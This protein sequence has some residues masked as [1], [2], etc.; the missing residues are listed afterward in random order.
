LLGDYFVGY[1]ATVFNERALALDTV[2]VYAQAIGPAFAN[3]GL[4]FVP[5]ILPSLAFKMSEGP[6]RVGGFSPPFFCSNEDGNSDK[7]LGVSDVRAS[8][9]GAL[10]A[11]MECLK[12][13]NFGTLGASERLPD[14][15]FVPIMTIIL[16]CI[17][18]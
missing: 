16:T 14:A 8:A 12:K 7:T 5:K 9:C 3:Y 4:E 6:C 15:F 17:G 18:K 11:L 10:S 13:A 2:R 1:K